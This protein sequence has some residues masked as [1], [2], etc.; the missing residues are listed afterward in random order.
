MPIT[1]S[2]QNTIVPFCGGLLLSLTM[3][4]HLYLKG[5][6]TNMSNIFQGLF[7]WDSTP[8]YRWKSTF[9]AGLIV[10][11]VII[12]NLVDSG[13]TAMTLESASAYVSGLSLAGWLISALLIGVGTRLVDGDY[14]GALF[15]GVPRKKK[16]AIISAQIMIAT[17]VIVATLNTNYGYTAGSTMTQATS[18]IPTGIVANVFMGLA[19]AIFVINILR[20]KFNADGRHDVWVS[21]V[22]GA[23]YGW[24]LILSGIASRHVV[25]AGLAISS[26][27]SPALLFAFLGVLLG[28]FL[29][30]DKLLRKTRPL[31]NAGFE[32][33]PIEQRVI[34]DWQTTIGSILFGTGWGLCGICP[35]TSLLATAFYFPQVFVLFIPMLMIGKLLGGVLVG[36]RDGSKP[37]L[38]RG[39]LKG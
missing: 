13:A 19:I 32:L 24:G 1:L 4:L 37:G 30:F 11:S 23:M 36:A 17:A 26:S 34:I 15:F 18:D 10:A 38:F 7:I 16:R 12:Y 2:E 21:F 3:T 35:G 20:T 27:W 5:R 6:H 22:I 39:L 8:S 31:Y 9:A 14:S 28:N 25:L 29:T 33:G